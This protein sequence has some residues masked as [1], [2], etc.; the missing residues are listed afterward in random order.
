MVRAFMQRLRTIAKPCIASTSTATLEQYI[1]R[2][3]LGIHKVALERQLL[4][5]FGQSMTD[6][7]FGQ[8][9]D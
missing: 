7:N 2:G 1:V 4:K 3:D 8:P 5:Q 6:S 9:L